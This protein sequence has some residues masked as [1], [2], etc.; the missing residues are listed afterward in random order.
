MKINYDKGIILIRYIQM[1]TQ[2]KMNRLFKI[3]SKFTDQVIFPV[4]KNNDLFKIEHIEDKFDMCYDL[5][6]HNYDI[7]DGLQ[8]FSAANLI[9]L[10]DVKDKKIIEVVVCENRIPV[11]YAF[12]D[13][14]LIDRLNKNDELLNKNY[15]EVYGIYHPFTDM[16]QYYEYK[17]NSY[18]K[19]EVFRPYSSALNNIN[20]YRLFT[21]DP[22][23]QEK[24]EQ[25]YITEISYKEYTTN[26]GKK[27][28]YIHLAE[29]KDEESGVFAKENI[30]PNA[31][32]EEIH[33]YEHFVRD[34]AFDIKSPLEY[35]VQ[36]NREKNTN[37]RIVNC[38]SGLY[39]QATKPILKGEEIS[40]SLG[41]DYWVKTLSKKP[42]PMSF[43]IINLIKTFVSYLTTS[44]SS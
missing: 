22:E 41:V 15:N 29:T 37:A 30:E 5:F 3:P 6:S 42:E 34:L 16:F 8:N 39:F 19:V 25:C 21:D 2:S 20:M 32:F 10:I 40:I 9:F 35:T 38:V 13:F 11:A 44:F 1:S 33:D 36:D 4:L 23:N 24:T 7:P 26:F 18:P 14:D 17:S 31:I 28:I 43:S 27:G 12:K